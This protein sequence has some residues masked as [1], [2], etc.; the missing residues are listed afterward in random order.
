[1][2]LF[3]LQAGKEFVVGENRI[4]QYIGH[5]F[6]VHNPAICATHRVWAVL[7]HIGWV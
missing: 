7:V 3:R 4:G 1:M 2:Q 6:I 5:A